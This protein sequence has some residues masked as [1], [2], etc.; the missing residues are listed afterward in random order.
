MKNTWKKRTIGLAIV[1][2]MLFTNT[3]VSAAPKDQYT[4]ASEVFPAAEVALEIQ[5]AKE[6]QVQ[7]DKTTGGI[8]IQSFGTYPTRYGVI[9][10]TAD[11]YKGLIPTGHAAIIWTSTTVVE[12]LSGGVTTGPNNWNT[13]KSTCYGVTTYGTT[14]AQDNDASNWCYSQKGKPYNWN[15]YDV[16]TRS[17]FYCSQLVYAAFLDLYGINLNTSD[18]GSA[19]HPMELVNSSNTYTVY[20]K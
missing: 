1:V 8:S 18:F 7:P 14:A 16:T 20:Q 12:S 9:L 19:I 17:K 11:A 13:S 4:P 3:G 10:V 5:E 2:M 6:Q 15:Y